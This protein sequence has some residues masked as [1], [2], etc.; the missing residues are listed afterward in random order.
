MKQRLF[1]AL[2]ALLLCLCFVT[3]AFAAKTDSSDGFVD[4]YSRVQDF[5]DLLTDDEEQ[6]L[7]DQLDEISVRQKMDIIV[8]TTDD[9]DGESVQDYADDLYDQGEFGYGPDK[10]GLL[11]LISM[12][13]HDWYISTC[14]YGITAFTDAG[15]Q[16]IGDQIKEDLGD[17]N[18]AAAFSTFAQQCDAFITQARTDRPYDN[19]NLPHDP[20]SMIWIPICIAAGITLA[21]LTVGTMKSQLKGVRS[22]PS[23]NSY[24][25]KDSLTVTARNELFLYRTVSRR[26]RPKDTDTDSGSSTHTSS[27]GQT[28]GGGGGKF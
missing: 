28:H 21:C 3:P 17:G 25:R 27:S 22:Q 18:Y 4:K 23:A 8:A 13:D 7:L 9:L 26:E 14:G 11:L 19:S 12:E 24:L 1:S 16:Y 6:A 15:I 5:A 20:L 2:T 10:D